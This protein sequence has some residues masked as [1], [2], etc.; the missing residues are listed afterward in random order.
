MK[1]LLLTLALVAT[2]AHAE[3]QTGN[4]VHQ[5]LN[6]QVGS[7]EHSYAFGYVIGAFDAHMNVTVCPPSNITQGQVLD[8][9]RNYLRANPQSRHY[10]A[11]SLIGVIFQTMWPCQRGNGV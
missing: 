2:S 10:S 4:D 5:G 6:S 11:D 9:T 3:F 1:T 7:F 8:M